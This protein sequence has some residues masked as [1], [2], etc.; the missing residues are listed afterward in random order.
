MSPPIRHT[1]PPASTQNGSRTVAGPEL[2]VAAGTF[3]DVTVAAAHA[4]RDSGPAGH[5]ARIA[6][7]GRQHARTIRSMEPTL[8]AAE[9]AADA[10]AVSEKATAGARL[11][12]AKVIRPKV[13]VSSGVAHAGAPTQA[14]LDVAHVMDLVDRHGITAGRR[15]GIADLPKFVIRREVGAHTD[16][17]AQ[18]VDE[19]IRLS[20]RRKAPQL[21]DEQHRLL[22]LSLAYVRRLWHWADPTIAFLDAQSRS[23]AE[24]LESIVEFDRRSRQRS[25]PHVQRRDAEASATRTLRVA[26]L[27]AAAGAP[28]ARMA[29]TIHLEGLPQAS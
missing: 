12:A 9:K 5:A 13:L 27:V 19:A 16:S 24:L 17:F 6:A 11:I 29:T 10:Y 1:S 14:T 20:R 23:T 7:V 22:A 26:S 15:Y 28:P 4:T 3:E 2:S 8:R 18:V 25:R 21:F